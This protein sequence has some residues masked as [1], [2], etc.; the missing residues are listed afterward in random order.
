M[1]KSIKKRYKLIII[2]ATAVALLFVLSYYLLQSASIQTYI[3]RVLTS[4]ISENIKS[5]IRV[6]RVSFSFF[7]KLSAENILILDQHN[8]T[9]LFTPKASVTLRSYSRKEKSIGFGKLELFDP[10][11]KFITDSSGQMNLT[12]YLDF[13]KSD[14]VKNDSTTM[15]VSINQ[16]DIRNGKFAIINKSVS[17]KVMGSMIDFSDMRFEEINAIAEDF[18]LDDGLLYFSIH[19]ISMREKRGLTISRFTSNMVIEPTRITFGNLHLITRNSEIKSPKIV[20]TGSEQTGFSD[21]TNR[22]KMDITLESSSIST[23]DIIYFIPVENIGSKNIKIAGEISG[24]VSELKGRNISLSYGENTSLA[25]EFDFSGLPDIENTFMFL[26]VTSLTSSYIDLATLDLMKFDKKNSLEDLIKSAGKFS[27]RGKFTGF[28][29]DFVTYGRLVTDVGTISTDLSLRPGGQG[30]FTYKGS[31][32]GSALNAGR[33]TN[34][35][36]LLGLLSLNVKIDGKTTSFEDFSANLSGKIDSI[37]LK[38]YTYRN[39]SLDGNF[40]NKAWDGSLKISEPNI[41]MDLLGRFLL[42]KALPEFDFTL[43]LLHANLNKL[44]LSKE[45]T[46]STLSVLMTSNFSG[47]SIDNLRGEIKL[48]NSTMT[49]YGNK[50]DVYDF[51]LTAQPEEMVPTLVLRTDFLDLDLKGKYKFASIGTTAKFLISRIIPSLSTPGSAL[52]VPE[53][54]EFT[55]DAV[56]KETGELNRFLRTN[57]EL[58]R[59]SH[60]WGNISASGPVNISFTSPAISLNQNTIK[61]MNLRL[62]LKDTVIN[63]SVSTDM[64][65]ISN[66]IELDG[67]SIKIDGVPDNLLLEMLWDNEQATENSGAIELTGRFSRLENAGPTLDINLLP[68]EVVLRNNTWDLLPATVHIDSTSLNFSN[69]FIRNKNNFY[70]LNGRL[71]Q[72][73]TDSLT[74]EMKGIDLKLLNYMNN[75]N[76]QGSADQIPLSLAGILNGNIVLK[77]VYKDLRFEA[78]VSVT[79]FSFLEQEYGLLSI[80]S[81]W[82]PWRKLAMLSAGNDYN[83]LNFFNI[84]GH[85]DP[86]S[87][88]IQLDAILKKMPVN[89]LNPLLKAFA[90]NIAGYA[91]GKVRLTGTPATINV[92]GAIFAEDGSMKVDYLQTVYR[93]ADS[94]RFRDDGIYFN[95]VSIF[96]ER[97]N[98]ARVNG[99][100]GHRY[101]RDYS[102]DLRFNA[103]NFMGL[104]TRQKD[105]ELFYGTAFANGVI[106]IKSSNNILNFNISAKTGRNTR[107]F[108]PLNFGT[109]LSDY[110]F[111]TFVGSETASG[112]KLNIP[113]N[114]QVQTTTTG[115]QLNFDLEVTP[116]AEVQLILDSKAGDVMRGRGTGKL[117]INLDSKGEFKISG[118][119]TVEDGDYLFTLGNILNKRFSVENGGTITWDGSVTDAIIDMKAIYKTKASLYD[120]LQDEAFRERIPVE[121]HLDLS[122]KLINPV[123]GFNIY[124]P[125]ADEETRTYLRNAINTE[126]EMS[127]QFLYLAGNEQFLPRSGILIL[128]CIGFNRYFCHGCYNN[129]NAF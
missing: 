3:V 78:N 115:I 22:V 106:N 121:C 55:F 125:T 37:E 52:S 102:V 61:N 45:D 27:F 24:A 34:N 70:S 109:E 75:E 38:G 58:A 107:F 110:S 40:A 127:R 67:F 73:P 84:N 118:V 32:V 9:L 87:K 129:G 108:V 54:N 28:T 74:I 51:T 1:G 23:A 12:W 15:K 65:L 13:L 92:N 88:D 66:R 81:V 114:Q 62:D 124:L 8:D 112:S 5:T 128:A 101:F 4:K 64:V 123:I 39:V 33:I 7:N 103:D 50:L 90:S 44:N 11:I 41:D 86:E 96:D 91:S 94:I 43:N 105:N 6:D 16:V 95:N 79:D 36:D 59:N 77:D 122:D 60:L 31:L 63:T 68:S 89:I 18:T 83:G 56:F 35:M 71:S 17:P 99:K 97:N 47:N 126:E 10:T 29:T 104:N 2:G 14:K 76:L 85:Y 20:L 48:L 82:D 26:N 42:D 100:V 113:V 80:S 119:Y 53:G 93:F 57:L 116:D 120:I 69:L 72:D 98:V 19:G 30:K 46:T 117:N 49:R 111:I 21:F 25:F